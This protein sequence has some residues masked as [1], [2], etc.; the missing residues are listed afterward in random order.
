MIISGELESGRRLGEVQLASELGISRIPLREALRQLAAEGFVRSE[1]Y[2]GTYVAQMDTVA[3]H[4][5]LDVRSA[6]EPLAAA[7]AATN[8]SPEHLQAL[9]ELVKESERA[10]REQRFEDLSDWRARFAEQ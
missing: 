3:A 8:C 1:G 7:Q 2:G 6:L 10:S 4:E 5:L 9:Y